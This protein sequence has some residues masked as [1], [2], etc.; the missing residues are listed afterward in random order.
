MRLCDSIN[1]DNNID[2]YNYRVADVSVRL[3]INLIKITKTL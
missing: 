3:I 1:N 2:N